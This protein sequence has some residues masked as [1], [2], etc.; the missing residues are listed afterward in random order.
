MTDAR[1]YH[2]ILRAL[3]AARI[4]AHATRVFLEIAMTKLDDVNAALDE[5]RADV[6]AHEAREVAQDAKDQALISTLNTTIEDLR[7]QLAAGAPGLTDEQGQQLIDKITAIR[8]IVA[9]PTVPID[10]FGDPNA[11]QAQLDAAIAAGQVPTST[12]LDQFRN[13]SVTPL[14]RRG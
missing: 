4:H 9:A 10:G 2:R 13:G 11:T 3:R 5:A 14:A 12:T 8:T 6:E 1:G 7:A